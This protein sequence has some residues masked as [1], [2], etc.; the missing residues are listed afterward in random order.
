M[1]TNLIPLLQEY[2]KQGYVSNFADA[3]HAYIQEIQQLNGE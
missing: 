2:L 3:I 1:Q